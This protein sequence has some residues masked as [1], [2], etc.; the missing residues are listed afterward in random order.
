MSQREKREPESVKFWSNRGTLLHC[1]GALGDDRT[2]SVEHIGQLYPMS[3]D[4]NEMNRTADLKEPSG[5]DST[6]SWLDIMNGQL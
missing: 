5:L 2:S 4:L 3:W 1:D 6:V